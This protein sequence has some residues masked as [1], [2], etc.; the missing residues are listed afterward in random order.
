M[1]KKL[2]WDKARFPQTG[3]D[4]KTGNEWARGPDSFPV[5][6]SD[7][8]RSEKTYA[9]ERRQKQA[10][11]VYLLDNA[12]SPETSETAEF[13]EAFLAEIGITLNE[14]RDWYER[15]IRRKIKNRRIKSK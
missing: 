12:L 9:S 13:Q 6:E 1:A 15:N 5:G 2:S 10:M 7:R 8:V 4:A 3:F 11:R 14:Y